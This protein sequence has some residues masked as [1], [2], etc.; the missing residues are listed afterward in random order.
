MGSFTASCAEKTANGNISIQD[1]SG[2]QDTVPVAGSSALLKTKDEGELFQ[3]SIDAWVQ[4][5]PEEREAT[6][7][8]GISLEGLVRHCCDGKMR[9]R[10]GSLFHLYSQENEVGVSLD[11]SWEVE[12]L[13]LWIN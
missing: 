13:Y 4:D 2:C 12:T 1:L 3:W 6:Y 5:G 10:R 8:T 11:G 7:P 9:E